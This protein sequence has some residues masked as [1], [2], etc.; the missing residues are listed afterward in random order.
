MRGLVQTVAVVIGT[1]TFALVAGLLG[2]IWRGESPFW[3]GDA[4]GSSRVRD[5]NDTAVVMVWYTAFYLT[6]CAIPFALLWLWSGAGVRAP[7][8]VARLRGRIVFGTW[9]ALTLMVFH[10]QVFDLMHWALDSANGFGVVLWLGFGVGSIVLSLN[11]GDFGAFGR[12][13]DVV[14]S[15]N[16]GSWHPR[17]R[18]TGEWS[19]GG[20]WFTIYHG[21][22]RRYLDGPYGDA[23]TA[24]ERAKQLGADGV[25]LET[26]PGS[27]RFLLLP[28]G[29]DYADLIKNDSGDST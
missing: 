29:W 26:A 4:L 3:I 9:I 7:R 11:R 24:H 18:Y 21:R 5:W 10:R 27:G 12:S 2:E 15:C 13:N 19:L 16:H 20:T 25:W 1:L 6:V 23:V 8:L 14:I 22:T 28:P 17:S